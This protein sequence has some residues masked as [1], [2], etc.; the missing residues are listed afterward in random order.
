M[1]PVPL[2]GNPI[3]GLLLIHEKVAPAVGLEKLIA[4][5]LAPEQAVLFVTASTMG[6]GQFNELQFHIEAVAQ[7][8][9]WGVI[10]KITFSP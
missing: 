9:P 4:A 10:V 7:A 8:T 1:L 3:D 5:T 6:L 2:A